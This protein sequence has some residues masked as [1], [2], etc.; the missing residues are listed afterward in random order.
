M[1]VI[2]MLR[3]KADV[4][5]FESYAAANGEQLTRIAEEGR[6]RGA[7]HHMFT[8]ADGELVVIDE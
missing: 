7:I 1:T 4:A 8:A 5:A 6:S 2:M 3:V